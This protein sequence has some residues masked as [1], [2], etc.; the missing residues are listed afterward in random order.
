[1]AVAPA[2]NCAYTY[3]HHAPAKDAPPIH[4]HRLGRYYCTV[5]FSIA[6]L[7]IAVY[8]R[9]YYRTCTDTAP[10]PAAAPYEV[11]LYL[12]IA[13]GYPRILNTTSNF[14]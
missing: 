10:V 8:Y 4:R 9:V 11:Y 14:A 5:H 2:R 7:L 6:V 3:T 13:G 1:M 12:K